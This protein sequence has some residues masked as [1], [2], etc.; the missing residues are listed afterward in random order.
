ME[1]PS[2]FAHSRNGAGQRHELFGHLESVA[3]LAAHF[4]EPYHGKELALFAG[5]IHDLG[6]IHP[7]WQEYLHAVEHDPKRKGTG[8]DHKGA[9]ALLATQKGLDLLAFL[10]AGHHGSLPSES[11]LRSWLRERQKDTQVLEAIALAMSHLPAL[12][13]ISVAPPT[14]LRTTLETE[15][16]IR[17][18]YSALVDADFLDTERHFAPD[19][20]EQR[21][22]IWK[23]ETLWQRLLDAHHKLEMEKADVATTT[24]GQARHRIYEACLTKAGEASGFFRLTV[25]T[26][27]GK[28]L[29][30]L[31]FAIRHAHIHQCQRIIYAIPYLSITEQ[32]ADVFRAIF[33]EEGIVLEHH[34]GVAQ[35]DDPLN[36]PM[37]TIWQRIAIENWDALLII[38]TAV[39]LFESLFGNTPSACRKLHNIAQSVIVLDEAQMLPTHLLTPLLDV[40]QQLVTQYG[41]TIVFCTATQPALEDRESF[42][43]LRQVREIIE[44]P[45][46]LFT[47]LQRV[48]YHWPQPGERWSWERVAEEMEKLPQVL[49]IVNTK[50]DALTVF[51]HLHDPD[52]LHLSTLMCGAH[53]RAL[54]REVRLRLRHKKPCRLISTQLIEAGVDVDFPLVL[55][56]MAPFDSILQA[57]GRANR[58]GSLSQGLVI[59]FEPISQQLPPG[60]YRTGTD[61]T[62][63]LLARGPIDC[64]DLA[65][66]E[67]YFTL[68]YRRINRDERAI[69]KLRTQF[70]YP[71][72]STQFRLIT[73]ETATVVVRYQSPDKPAEVDSFLDAIR[74]QGRVQRSDWRCLQPYLVHL[75]DRVFARFK[76]RGLVEEVVT[77]LWVWKDSYDPQ[78]GLAPHVFPLREG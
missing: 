53:R 54:L 34:S 6:K 27:G 41:C 51:R 26:G 9:G 71:E 7:A 46:T 31:A 32:T 14:H 29:S 18:L 33:P 57:G 77:G 17:M 20:A 75:D 43:G 10:I 61:T 16:Y 38:T 2:F 67:R 48:H 24:L 60:P 5:K 36:A 28:T 42:A 65:T 44:D 47:Q 73:D 68:Y 39:Q 13:S 23:W 63:E 64:S 4:A 72:V 8:P 49:T 45:A 37:G 56:A 3:T 15:L 78:S 52:A 50:R 76:Q 1:K 55:R 19:R 30:G 35:P 11:Q 25:P 12:R 22:N 74:K 69:Q 62:R 59:V 58:E 66:I 40:L 21:G 70:D